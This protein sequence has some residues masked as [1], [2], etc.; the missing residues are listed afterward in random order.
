ML[1]IKTQRNLFSDPV[2]PPRRD[3]R[4]RTY[5]LKAKFEKA[6]CKC[7]AKKAPRQTC[8]PIRS[9]R[10]DATADFDQFYWK[11]NLMKRGLP[12]ELSTDPV[13][14]PRRDR[15]SLPTWWKNIWSTVR[16]RSKLHGS[17]RPR[18]GRYLNLYLSHVLPWLLK[19]AMVSMHW[20][21]QSAIDENL[22]VVFLLPRPYTD[23]CSSSPLTVG[24]SA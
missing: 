7:S 4:F 17:R 22:T 1:N 18:S 13:A 6:N 8:P 16:C 19:I 9:R 20:L 2:A 3:H 5:W 15:R 23:T 11:R 24:L 21:D 12:L 10:R 14:A